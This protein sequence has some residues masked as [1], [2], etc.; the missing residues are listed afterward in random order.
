MTAKTEHDTRSVTTAHAMRSPRRVVDQTHTRKHRARQRVSPSGCISQVRA[1][2]R[3]VTHGHELGYCTSSTRVGHR[4]LQQ[5]RQPTSCR[6]GSRYHHRQDTLVCCGPTA[7]R[8]YQTTC[9]HM[10]APN[11]DICHM[12]AKQGQSDRARLVA[13]I[14]Q[15]GDQI[16]EGVALITETKQGS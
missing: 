4:G 11:I 9:V 16:C 12:H 13:Q 7:P 15:P 1:E 5:A 8:S 6:S 2:L 14:E 3:R 10:N